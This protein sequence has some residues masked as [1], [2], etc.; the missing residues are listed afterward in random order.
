MN[1]PSFKT[2]LAYLDGEIVEAAS[3]AFAAHLANGCARCAADRAWYES[4]QAIA[5]GDDSTDAPQWVL[6]RAVKLFEA[7]ATRPSFAER[8]GHLIAALV[9]DSQARSALAGARAV[10]AADRQLL[11]RANRFSIDL[12]LAAL[13]Q[14]RAELSGQILC[15]GEFQFESVSGLQL[16]LLCEGRPVLSTMTNHFGEFSMAALERGEYDLQIETDEIN[17]TVVGLPVA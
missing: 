5:A 6:K 11:Y 16:H 14:S 1:C 15:E 4:F 17:I 13:N 9:F 3:A 2:L 7:R 12:Q 10:A 8:V